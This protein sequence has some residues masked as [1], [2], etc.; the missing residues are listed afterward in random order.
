MEELSRETILGMEKN[1]TIYI[2]TP[3]KTINLMQKF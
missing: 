3:A 1:F 2:E